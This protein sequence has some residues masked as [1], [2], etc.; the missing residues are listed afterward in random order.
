MVGGDVMKKYTFTVDDTILVLKDL[1]QGDYHSIFEHPYLALVK[2]LHEKYGVKIQLNLF[3]REGDFA[4]TELKKTEEKSYFNLSNMTERYKEEWERCSNWLKMS[5]HSDRNNIRPY[6]NC[7]YQEIYDDCQKVHKEIIRF[8]GEKSLAKTITVHYC[9]YC[10]RVALLA[11]KDC[12]MV[13]ALGIYGTDDMPR[14]SYECNEETANRARRGELL[15]KDGITIAGIDIILNELSIPVILEKL[16]KIKNREVVKIMNHEMHF[17][18]YDKN[19][20][21]NFAE[22][23]ET[24]IAFL[25]QNGFESVF[26]EDII[27]QE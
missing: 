1:T 9:G 22:K 7:S 24:T 17:Y 8:A 3:Y 11:M 5:F 20:Q 13:G 25:V 23:M 10:K 14:Y 6:K 18:D 2:S 27:N 19:Y 15:V 21:S 4:V 26:F 16:N 12:G